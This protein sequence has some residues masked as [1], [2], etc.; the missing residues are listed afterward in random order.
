[1]GQTATA[2]SAQPDPNI[3]TCDDYVTAMVEHMKQSQAV[4]RSG[5]E[6]AVNGKTTYQ[7]SVELA[8][9]S[10]HLKKTGVF[11]AACHN[12]LAQAQA[13]LATGDPAKGE[14]AAQGLGLMQQLQACTAKCA[15]SHKPEDKEMKACMEKCAA[16]VQPQRVR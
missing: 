12:K 8:K 15:E 1:M 11:D 2:A 7:R 16:A 6:R 3:K 9:T 4:A 14:S 10:E 5:A 13:T